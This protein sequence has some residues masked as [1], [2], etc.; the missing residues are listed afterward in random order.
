MKHLNVD[1]KEEMFQEDM[2]HPHLYDIIH[3]LV[4]EI[5][6]HTGI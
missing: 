1:M 4:E 2:P 5:L 6:K 3:C